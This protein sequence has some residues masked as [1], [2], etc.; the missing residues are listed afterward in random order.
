[1]WPGKFSQ[2]KSTRDESKSS[3]NSKAFKRLQDGP[4]PVPLGDI[5]TAN[6][7]QRGDALVTSP[8]EPLPSPNELSRLQPQRSSEP[9]KRPGISVRRE[10]GIQQWD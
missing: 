3:A 8:V 2:H 6:E 1:M 9:L 5:Y 4:Q 7:N 10:W